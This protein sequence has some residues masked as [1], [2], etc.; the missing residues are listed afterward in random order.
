MRRVRGTEQ[1]QSEQQ[2]P[3]VETSQESSPAPQS[4]S[5]SSLLFSLLYGPTLIT[6]HDYWESHSFDYLWTFVS[7]VVSLLFNMLSRFV[8]VFPPMSKHLLI[9]WLQSI[10]AMISKPKKIKFVPDSIFPH[11]SSCS[12]QFLLQAKLIS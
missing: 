9:T 10:S 8:I 3:T 12:R 7:K 6:I 2:E 11:L 4:K 1:Q 5:I